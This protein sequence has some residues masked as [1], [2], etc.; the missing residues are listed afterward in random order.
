MPRVPDAYLDARREEI[1]QAA[2]RCFGREG[3]AG[4]SVRRIAEEADVSP[5]ALYHYFDD[6]A[7]ILRALADRSV[8][9]NVEAVERAR[10]MEDFAAGLGEAV[11][12][13]LAGLGTEDGVRSTR[14]NLRLW[15]EA[16]SSPALLELFG[17]AYAA[18]RDAVETFLAEA[19]ERGEVRDDVDPR[20]LAVVALSLL[21][22]VVFL[23]ALR[24]DLDEEVSLE[25]VRTVLLTGLAGPGD[26]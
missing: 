3:M 16:L 18:N 7:E 8:R 4:T 20:E 24:P 5:G 10:E 13:I 17:D 2:F 14:A 22:G 11:G 1:L 21:Q 6:K 12:R 15:A 19:A 26:D 23:Q 9:H 25:A